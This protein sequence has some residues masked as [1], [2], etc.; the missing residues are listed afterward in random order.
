MSRR[1]WAHI[2]AAAVAAAAFAAAAPAAAAR[3]AGTAS[4]E[5]GGTGPSA[6]GAYLEA[7]AARSPR[8][9]R[10]RAGALGRRRQ[11]LARTEAR[12]AHG[13]ALRGRPSGAASSRRRAGSPSSTASPPATGSRRSVTAHAITT[14]TWQA[15]TGG[16]DVEA[17]GVDHTMTLVRN[18]DAWRSPPTSTPTSSAGLPRGG[19]RR[20]PACGARRA[21]RA[22][23]RR[24]ACRGPRR[25]A[26]P[27]PARR[28]SDIIEYDRPAAQAYADTYALAYNPTFVRF[29][30]DCANFASQGARAGSMP[31]TSGDYSSGWW[32]DKNGTSS[33]SDDH[34]SLSWINVPKQMSYWNGRRT[35]WVTSA[36]ML[37]RGDFIYYD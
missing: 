23:S 16:T 21:R 14:L 20:A 15:A 3:Y 9:T 17:S 12:V 32:Y 30:A 22:A 31:V 24:R 33:T 1:H 4:G 10:R 7:R 36:G 11:G 5:A 29:G 34:Y 28:Y 6:T 2:V 18:G 8:P 25:G 19:R 37:S 26:R 13:T 27:A 35:D